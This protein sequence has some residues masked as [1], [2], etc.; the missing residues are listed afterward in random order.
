M[1]VDAP[2]LEPTANAYSTTQLL[3]YKATVISPHE[4][5]LERSRKKLI[6]RRRERDRDESSCDRKSAL[7][8][9]SKSMVQSTM[10]RRKRLRRSTE[11]GRCEVDE[12]LSRGLSG[13]EPRNPLTTRGA[14]EAYQALGGSLR[15]SIE[16]LGPQ[17]GALTDRRGQHQ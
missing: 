7:S 1:V 5:K 9:E 8:S 2:S 12:V 10:N 14:V 4:S 13:D 16:R 11:R 6:Q 15:L 3:S 17:E